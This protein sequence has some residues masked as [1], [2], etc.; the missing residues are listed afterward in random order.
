MLLGGFMPSEARSHARTN[1]DTAQLLERLVT[2]R[3]HRLR[4]IAISVVGAE[5]ADDAVQAACL[6]FLRTFDPDRSYSSEEDAFRYLARSTSNAAAKLNRTDQRRRR[7]LPPVRRTDDGPDPIEQATSETRNPCEDLI[8]REELAEGLA[9]LS[10]LPKDQ[11]QVLID[12]AAGYKPA[13]IQA[14]SGLSSR[15]YR[16]RIEKARRRLGT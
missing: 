4:R 12:R 5:Q 3:G 6:G 7:G 10:S 16:K 14:R 13:E 2:E 8:L 9:L 11:Q 15:Q 1:P